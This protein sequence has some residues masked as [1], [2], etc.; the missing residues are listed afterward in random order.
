[1]TTFISAGVGSIVSFLKKH[2]GKPGRFHSNHCVLYGVGILSAVLSINHSFAVDSTWNYAVQASA[3]T[4][5]S[6]PQIQLT[7]PQDTI[8]VPQ[9]YT[10]YRKALNATAWG[11]GTTLPGSATNYVDSNVAIGSAYEYQI[12]KTASTYTG[13]GYVYAGVNVPLMEDRGKVILLVDNTFTSSL[14]SELLRLQ[15]DLVGDGWTVLRHDVS[16]TATVPSIKA[17]I[18]ADY[19]ADPSRVKGVFLFGHIPVPYSGNIVPDGH[20]PDHQGAWP[21]D[22]YYG[23]MDGT[24]TD[25]SVNI[26]SAKDVANHNIPGD[27]KFDQSSPPSAI[28]LEVGRV[29]LSNMPGKLT[30]SGP[31][32]FPSEL[33]LLRQYLNKD[34]RFRHGLLTAP[35]RGLVG[36]FFG[37]RNGEAFAASG[38]RNMAPFFGA[39]NI[40]S[41][42]NKGEWIQNLSAN[43]YLWAYGC[44]AG[45]YSTIGGLGSHGPYN[46]VWS[47]DIVQNDAKAIFVML[48]GSWLGDWDS[49]DNI[50]RSIL[51]TPTYGLT[52]AWSGR[53]HWFFQHMG[54]GGT[55]GF[56]AKLT[57][58]NG[59]G[60]LYKNQVNSAAGNIHVALMGDP[61]L[62]MHPVGPISGLNG[63]STTGGIRLNWT[64][65]AD[66]VVGYHVYRTSSTTVPF[67]RLTTLPITGV[68]YTDSAVS[69]GTYAYMVRAVKLESSGSGTYYNASQGVFV[70]VSSTGTPGGTLPSIN[71]SASKANASEAGLV[72]G[73]F[74]FTRTGETSNPIAIQY[75]LSGIAA[76]GADYQ[77]IANQVTIPSGAGSVT[78]AIKPIDDTLQ[79][80]SEV[81]ILTISSN[82]Q[83]TIGSQNSA[84][85]TIADNDAT[86]GGGG[87]IISPVIS[88]TSPIS[89]TT[90]SGSNVQISANATDNVGVIGVK[91][92]VDGA[93]L[94]TE[95]MTGPYGQNWDTT[96]VANGAH[97]ITA[98]AR[99]AAGNNATS[100]PLS[101]VVQNTPPGGGGK[102]D[103]V[104]V[105]D[106][107]PAGAIAGAD[108]G[109]AW[110][111]ITSSPAPFSGT[112]A[113]Q[114]NI[115]A[116]SH[117]HFFDNA[118]AK[119][120]ILTGDTL[121]A[122]VYLDPANPPAEIMLQWNNANWEH[123]AYWG[124]NK[125]TY[126]VDGTVSRRYMGALP[127]AG[128]WVRLEVPASAVGLEG[129]SLK[130]MAFSLHGGRATWDAAGKSNQS[131]PPPPSPTL[132]SVSITTTDSNSAEEG[133]NP[134]EFTLTRTGATSTSLTVNYAVTGTATQGTDYS[135]IPASISIPVGASSAKIVILPGDDTLVEADESVIMTVSSNSQYT[136]SAPADAS[137]VIVDN[138]KPLE[139]PPP[140]SIVDYTALQLPSVG[141]STLHILSPNMLE[142]VYIN[143][144]QPDPALIT[145]WNFV[146]TSFQLVPPNT[147][148]FVVTING[149][150]TPVQSVGFKRR[151][152]Y[153]PLIKRDLRIDNRLY[154]QLASAIKEGDRVEVKNPSTSLWPITTQYACTAN[155]LRYSPAIHV[156]QEGYVPNFPKKAMV[157]YYVGSFGE[158]EVPTSQGFNIVDAV[159]GVTAYSGALTQR[160]DV[161]YV[162]TPTPYQ[163]VYQADFSNFKIPGEYRLVVPGLGSSLPFLIDDG[164]A[165]SFARTYALGLYH[166]RCGSDNVMPFTR[167]THDDCHTAPVQVPV[168]QSLFSTTWGFISAAN[169]DYA[170]NPRHTAPQLKDEASQLYPFV[171][172]G[173]IDV[174]GGHHDAGDYSKYT[175]N[176]AGLVHYLMFAVDNFPGV[177]GLD[178][179]GLPES[180]DGISDLMQEAKVEAD[181]LAKLQDADGGFYFI[182]Y[183]RDR[184]YESN[185]TPDH[186]DPQVVWPKNTLSTATAVA[187]LAQTA[188]SPEFKRKYPADAARYLQK[189]KLGWDF[190]TNAIAKY[191]KDGSY[192]K[193]TFY[194]DIFMHDDEL[195][196][197]ACELY[198]AT[199]EVKYQQKLLEWFDPASPA[200][201][202]WGWWR[203]WEAYGRAARS[204]AFA[205]RNGRLPSSQLDSAFLAKCE[206]ELKLCADDHLLRASD[207]AYGTSFPA[208]TKRVRGAGW[209]FSSE[210][211]YDI[212]VAYQ[213]NQRP[214]Y[215]DAIVS[216]LN[217]EGGSN[218]VNAS[219]MTGLGW[220]RQREIV[221]QYAQ[222]DRRVMPPSG[223]PLGN[224]QAA[225]GYLDKYKSELGALCFPQ[226]GAANSPYPFYD[227]WADSFNVSTEFVHLDQARGVASI[228]YLATLTPLKNQAWKS[229]PATIDVPNGTLSIGTPV[230]VT[231]Q[232]PGM[233]LS[234]TRV[235]WEAQDQEP[236]YGDNSYTFTPKS[237]GTPWIEAEVQWP[238]GRRVFATNSLQ[239][240]NGL[241]SISVEATDS[242]AAEAGSDSATFRF[243]RTGSTDAPLIFNYQFTG[244]AAK[245]FDYKRPQGDIPTTLTIPAGSSA[246]D[247]VI[248]PI[249]DTTVEGAESVAVTVSPALSYNVGSPGTAMATIVDND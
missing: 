71:I 77:N 236:S 193:I 75:A 237:N 106:A 191:G 170:S 150:V 180:G 248:N 10:I 200:T 168:P 176:S 24:W 85:V 73:E 68:S 136:V 43:S 101:V 67:T 182:V 118:T 171:N 166:Q 1:M 59:P 2:K 120:P 51:A 38:W 151:P 145:D 192:Q 218:P 99:D 54:L 140:V 246:V 158:M 92:M 230:T 199:G 70:D 58:N 175:I 179:M 197:A 52:C 132:P 126:G 231:L 12:V 32:T 247:L 113:T 125:I 196:W 53:P 50:M 82:S 228:A 96:K 46:D 102:A 87:D 123:R 148:E 109:D 133:K 21:A 220:K 177:A 201:R 36:D 184:K 30:W 188:S 227:R 17:L 112:K 194:G 205:A 160:S 88:L 98:V 19:N 174:S 11:A 114:S 119:L 107:L 207:N 167:F 72:A 34:H 104:W 89:S 161:G 91:F 155:P 66:T 62:R 240:T 172:K 124:A 241:P 108:G 13:Y 147:S 127:A 162:Y 128:Q 121:F 186:G 138:D 206:T 64:A 219:Y 139:P 165:M 187:A 22:V 144:K 35:R 3:T 90:V 212:T 79:E 211:A 204:Y 55:V 222:N 225:F 117:Q 18:K 152:M 97:I 233:D 229:S 157:G 249:D 115:S 243:T 111:W 232:V 178:N 65:S 141:D 44:G 23:D 183:P 235:L 217:Y 224:I 31:A 63:T 26:T 149:I 95:D 94:G 181:Y 78:L 195:A 215:L 142:L 216:N 45:S 156:N 203:C 69:T 234:G 135:S 16:K 137:F 14:A 185:V 37:V 238:D 20:R 244:S 209:Y 223:I 213:L 164:I 76:N 130:G 74:T 169:A 100:A 80:S 143:T 28:E 4:Q 29:D 86:G 116:G 25:T 47:T 81:V 33:E 49:D 198:L 9:N 48:F 146:N 153:A 202:R 129:S 42:A 57:Q 93:N 221:H 190:L 131:S 210:R 122:Y 103:V 154:L 110:S 226:D 8:A 134:G 173:S 208:E 61:T 7:W 83:Y 245:W 56:G 189:A 60:G 84:T 15:L 214:D 5:V 242:N 159:S 40:T 163:K 239:T 6:P 39:S 105:E 41:V 27:G